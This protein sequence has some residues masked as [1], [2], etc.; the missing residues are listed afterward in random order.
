V[1]IAV[2]RERREGETRVALVPDLVDRL[3]AG[4]H[5]VV[6]EPGAGELAGFADS[7]YAAA[8]AL[9]DLAALPGA[10]LVLA[11]QAL[12]L[13]QVRALKPGSAT[14]AFGPYADPVLA[15][16]RERDVAAYAMELVPR[17]SR[18]QSM[19]ALTSQSLVAGYRAVVVA[20][21]LLQR[22]FALTSTAAGT[23]PAARVLVLGTG[24]AG[25]QAIATARRLGAIVSGYDVRASSAEEIASLGATPLDLGL[26]PLDGAAGYAREMTP[27]RS[28]RQQSLLA[29]YVARA[30]V[31]ITTAAVPGRTAPMLVTRAMVEAMAPGSVV[32]DLAAEGGGNV[33]GA[34]PAEVVTIGRAVVWGGANVPGQMPRMA[35]TLY[36]QNVVNLVPLVAGPAADPSDEIVRACRVG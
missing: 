31:L 20:A 24:V 25:L 28:A 23:L 11:V 4:G 10:E 15:V 27:E 26:D 3:T 32:V 12:E 16:L 7:D 22:T 18:A 30:D 21:D 14:I 13:E 17:I 19:D 9:V 33:E 29:P 34:L 35:S 1:R 2:V 6:V 36:A 5:V 8:G